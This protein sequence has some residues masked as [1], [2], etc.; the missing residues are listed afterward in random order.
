M[1]N[2]GKVLEWP[3]QSPDCHA[4]I[5]V[6]CVL[7]IC[8]VRPGC[9]MGLYVVVRIAVFVLLGLRLSRGVA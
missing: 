1:D 9:D 2:K 5:I 6:F 7:V 3:W 8:L 4:L